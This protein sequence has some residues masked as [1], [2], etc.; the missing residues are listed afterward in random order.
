MLKQNGLIFSTLVLAMSSLFLFVCFLSRLIVFH[1][2]LKFSALQTKVSLKLQV[3]KKFSCLL[4]C[5]NCHEEEWSHSTAMDLN[6]DMTDVNEAEL[7]I[8]TDRRM[9]SVQRIDE[10]AYLRVYVNF[11]IA[12]TWNIIGA[13]RTKRKVWISAVWV[14]IQEILCTCNEF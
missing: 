8:F 13:K 11:Y 6:Y 14:I 1:N 5:C 9:R 2:S 10:I 4:M 7:D 3:L 12:T